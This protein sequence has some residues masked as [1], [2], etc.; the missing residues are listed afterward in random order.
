MGHEIVIVKTRDEIAKCYAAFKAL[1]PHLDK[2]RFIEQ[3]LRQAE[4]S[5]HVVAIKTGNSFPSAAGFR[6]SEHLAWGRILYIDDL[7]TLPEYRGKGYAA[8]LMDWLLDHARTS[9][10]QGL[11]L[12]SGYARHDAHRLYLKKGLHLSSHHLSIEL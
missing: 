10:C 3:V 4:C 1:R 9:G 5:Y 12:D 11:H 2:E 7:T 6:F 8:A